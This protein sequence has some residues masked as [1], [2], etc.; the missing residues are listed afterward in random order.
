[1]GVNAAMKFRKV[2]VWL[3]LLSLCGGTII[4]AN[5]AAQKVRILVNGGELNDSGL[6]IDGKTYLPLRE[7][8]NALNAI[9]KWDNAN[10]RATVYKPNVHMFLYNK[11][12]SPFGVV[13]KGFQGKIKVFS[14]IDNL[15]TDIAAVK[16]SIVDPYGK[17][18]TIQSKDVANEMKDKDIFWFISEEF[19]YKFES[20]GIYTLRFYLKAESSEEW[21]VVSE[22]QIPSRVPKD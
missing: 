6:M 9:V 20:T 8:A 11:G 13:E 19:D 22:K 16:F 10:K 7:V 17:E 12:N 4:F 1:M 21:A 14:Q 15:Q 3:V 18:K 5:D 2:A